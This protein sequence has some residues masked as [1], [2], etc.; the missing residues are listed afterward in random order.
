M[1]LGHALV[2]GSVRTPRRARWTS[3]SMLERTQLRRRRG[4]LGGNEV[5][6]QIDPPAPI[7]V[8]MHPNAGAGVAPLAR[9]GWDIDDH[10]PQ[11]HGVIGEHGGLI[12]EAADPCEI[13][14]PAH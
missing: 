8:L 9:S 12:V 3:P 1:R 6:T 11:A 7:E 4:R 13:A 5:C 2:R 10:A 14:P